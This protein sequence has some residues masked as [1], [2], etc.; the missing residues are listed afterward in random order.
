MVFSQSRMT[1]AEIKLHMTNERTLIA[2]VRLAA[3][4]GVSAILLRTFARPASSAKLP[5]ELAP[6]QGAAAVLIA[7]LALSLYRRRARLIREREHVSFFA[8]WPPA[9]AG[10]TVVLAIVKQE[11]R[12]TRGARNLRLLLR[13]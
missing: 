13:R 11:E 1:T 7:V 5:K 9:I 10:V 8:S 2:W 6:A 12:C 4:L 3:T